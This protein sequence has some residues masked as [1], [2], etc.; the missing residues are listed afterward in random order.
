MRHKPFAASP[1]A[2][3]LHRLKQT[4]RLGFGFDGF[5]AIGAGDETGVGFLRERLL[6][7]IVRN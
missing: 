7:Q 5:F 2:A 3:N 4:A 1:S 6:R